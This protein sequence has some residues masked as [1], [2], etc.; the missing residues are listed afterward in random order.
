MSFDLLHLW[1]QMSGVVKAIL[2]LTILMGFASI[3]VAIERG[4]TFAKARVQSRALA[5]SLTE[6]LARGDVA[7]ALASTRDKA[8]RNAYLGHMLEA[9]LREVAV[10]L[11]RA[12]VD[13]ASRAM[14]RRA[15]S[16]SADMKRG[17]PILATTGSTAPFVGL[18]GTIFGIINAFQGMAE[19]GSG[20]LSSVAA[21]I[22][23]AL[24]ATAIGISVAI[25]GVWLY[26]FFNGR[27]EAITDDID[28]STQEFL[29]WCE[30]QLSASDDVTEEARR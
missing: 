18:V 9:G 28:V 3:Y 11:D 24:V 7:A 17:L 19:S 29:D 26:N 30:K 8:F 13:A 14:A 27:V 23:E 21:G 10:R 5:A 2:V 25:L 15:I 22:A 6:A 16:E 4:V 1:E 12:S 20:G